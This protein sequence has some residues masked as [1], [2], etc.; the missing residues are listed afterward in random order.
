MVTSE[1]ETETEGDSEVDLEATVAVV[2]E[3]AT[4]GMVLEDQ[5]LPEETEASA[6][7]EALAVT[8]AVAIIE[9]EA[10]GVTENIAEKD[11]TLVN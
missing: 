11:D 9:T 10:V 7:T 6:V 8:E 5:A 1:E 3:E 4:G 2:S